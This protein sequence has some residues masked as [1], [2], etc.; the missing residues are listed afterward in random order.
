VDEGTAALESCSLNWLLA[1]CV[2]SGGIH[3]G[4]FLF[5]RL[6]TILGF[7]ELLELLSQGGGNSALH[8]QFLQINGIALN[9]ADFLL[10]LFQ[11]HLRSL[12]CGKW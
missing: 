4:D 11:G 1:Q 9:L 2:D 8:D 12:L 10:I 6:Q 7:L 3:A 5:K